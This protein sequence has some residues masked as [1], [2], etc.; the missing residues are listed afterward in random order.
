MTPHVAACYASTAHKGHPH[1]AAREV[2]ARPYVGRLRM[3]SQIAIERS[4]IKFV[5]RAIKP[6]RQPTATARRRVPQRNVKGGCLRRAGAR[7]LALCDLSVALCV[8]LA[9]GHLVHVRQAVV[10]D[11][12]VVV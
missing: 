8:A 2:H 9:R 6:C 1:S 4:E 7:R 11:L 10:E 5:G 12:R 3:Q